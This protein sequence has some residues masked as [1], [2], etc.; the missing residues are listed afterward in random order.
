MPYVLPDDQQM[1]HDG[2]QEGLGRGVGHRVPHQGEHLLHV[3]Q[4]HPNV[5]KPRP[6]LVIVLVLVVQEHLQLSLEL[7]TGI[8]YQNLS[9]GRSYKPDFMTRDM[10]NVQQKA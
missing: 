1:L 9:S 6:E 7:F 8:L 5:V 4:L 2:E 3:V 10:W